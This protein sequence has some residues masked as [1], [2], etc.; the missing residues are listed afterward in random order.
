MLVQHLKQK[1]KTFVVV[2]IHAYKD[3]LKRG[4]LCKYQ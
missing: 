2:V 4:V 3:L 1:Q